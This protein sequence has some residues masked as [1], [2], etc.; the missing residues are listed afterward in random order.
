MHSLGG[1]IK[2]GV[3]GVG[4][5]GKNH[6]RVYSDLGVL[7]GIADLDIE[8]A[9]ALAGRFRSRAFSDYKELL[10]TD[11]D[12]VTVATPTQTHFRIAMDALDA[13][14]HVLIEK[15]ICATIEES[16][17]LIQAANDAGLT[18]A[19]GLIERH[20]PVV[21]FAK[22]AIRAGK[23]GDLVTVSGRRVSSFPAR[24]RDVGVIMDL[25]VHD[26]DVT[27]YLVGSPIRSVYALGG[28]QANQDFED[29]CNVL[30]DFEDGTTGFV[31]VN[32]LTPMK[33]RKLSLTC[34][35]NFVELD[36]I[37]QSARI[38]SSQIGD[39]DRSNLYN[40]PIEFDIRNISIRKKEPLMNEQV[41]FLEA[42][43]NKT[44]PLVTGDD[45][46][47]TIKVCTAAI[48]SMRTGQRVLMD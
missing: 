13:G 8:A 30:M 21:K 41:D 25:G 17:Q 4:S 16:E 20:N 31:E 11:L 7:G 14:K 26:I 34:M 44:R 40:I 2:A 47:Q 19:V 9:T 18:L 22:E 3:I 23:F 1:R 37:T 24:I 46:L 45:G 42:V 15:P 33:V 10:A 43:L 5:M 32:W 35:K 28:K 39:F 6:A 27:R 12:A 38:S 48:E 36:Y 29:H